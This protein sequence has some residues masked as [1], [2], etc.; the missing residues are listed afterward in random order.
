MPNTSARDTST[1]ATPAYD[2]DAERI[3]LGA[4]MTDSKLI[5]PV[6]ARLGALDFYNPR[7]GDL[8]EAI[9]AAH[10]SG[11]PTEPVALAGFLADQGTLSKYD[12][13]ATYL[14]T[15]LAAVPVAAQAMHYVDRLVEMSTRR[16][17]QAA[18][19]RITQA[20]TST[21]YTSEQVSAL[22]EDL[23]QQVRPARSDDGMTQLG[24]LLSEGLELIEHRKADPEG[25]PTGFVDLDRLLGGLRRKELITVAAPTG[26]GKS[27][28]LSDI[29]RHLAIKH[30][31]TV[32]WFSL[33][34]AKGELF[35]RII[36]A[37][38]GVPHHVI[39]SGDLDDGDWSRV[40][41]V[42]GPMSTAPLFICD[43]SEITVRQIQNKCRSLASRHGLDAVI[44]DYIQLVEPSKRCANE[45][46]QITDVSRMLKT[47]AGTLDVPVIGA[48]Q[49]NR[50]ADMRADK[51]PEL[52][53]LRGSGSIANNSNVVL[54]IHRPDYYD[55]ESPRRG[56]ADLCVRKARSAPKDV[57][58]VA[59][60][61]DKSRFVDM[62][63]A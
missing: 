28:F 11:I 44:V 23:I 1:D 50:N 53:D 40:S 52:S 13:G 10:D 35:D 4:L 30:K 54:M 41:N 45:Q 15:C 51:R 17:L 5:D 3:V 47:M 62:A 46:E 36:S 8:F 20:A 31:H 18:G 2:I 34:M 9:V 42:L 7:N 58:T 22:A 14:H 55:P 6:G 24:Q 48:A 19:I 43:Q 27:V 59:A 16:R 32:A 60:Q 56:E 39:R 33:E 61:L 49:M 21:G 63:I 29:A 26:A 57:V 38:A 25:L 12:G 37:Q